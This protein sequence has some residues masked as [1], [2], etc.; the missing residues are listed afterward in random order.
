[1]NPFLIFLLILLIF[2]GLGIGFV[3]AF[4]GVGGGFMNV[5]VLVLVCFLDIHVAVSASLFV[6]L[7][8]STSASI[9]YLRQKRVLIKVGLVLESAAIVGGIFASLLKSF[10]ASFILSY[11]F[12]AALA[13]MGFQIIYKTMKDRK[14]ENDVETSKE[15]N[16]LANARFYIIQ[17]RYVDAQQGSHFYKFNIFHAIPFMFCAGFV[18]GLIGI[19][20]GIIKVP[21]LL[22]V[23]GLPIHLATGTSSFM[24]MITALVN[25]VTNLLTFQLPLEAFLYGLTM[26]VGVVIGA[27]IG[28]RYSSRVP[29]KKL[30]IIFGSA[31]FVVSIYYLIYTNFQL[32]LGS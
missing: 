1:M 30:R 22:D 15:D 8:T 26:G 25:T 11:I 9:N 5:P 13:I 3:A 32:F 23:C 2:I 19:G 12:C 7:F 24:I 14:E 18:S 6:I 21:I 4:L 29:A 27:Q 10:I 28:A 16:S 31:L 17:G 20:G